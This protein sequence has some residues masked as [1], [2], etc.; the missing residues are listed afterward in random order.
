MKNVFVK[1][2]MAV[3]ALLLMTV[4]TGASN[5]NDNEISNGVNKNVLIVALNDN[6]KSNYFYPGMIADET[7]ISADSVSIIYNRIIGKNIAEAARK[8]KVNMTILAPGQDADELRHEIK[9]VGEDENIY[10]DLSNVSEQ[11]W[12]TT[13]DKAHAEY[14]LVLNQHYLKWQ[15]DLQLHTL[16][17]IVSFSLFDENKNEV[18]RGNAYFSSMNL[19][20]PQQMDKSCTKSAAKIANNVIKHI[21]L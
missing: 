17:H 5:K 4:Y 10:A 9:L 8:K 18:Y 13:M 6:V 19:L 12:K 21:K 7:G 2:G 11:V 16:F 1:K 15:E 14:A 3:F 20:A